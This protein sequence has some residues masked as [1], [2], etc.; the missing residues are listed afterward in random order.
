M[1]MNTTKMNV[2]QILKLCQDQAVVLSVDG[3][4]LNASFDQRPTDQLIGL[5]R[6]NKAALVAAITAHQAQRKLTQA[7]GALI[8]QPR[9]ENGYGLS[10]AQTRLWMAQKLS[11]NSAN[12]NMPIALRVTGAFDYNIAKQAFAKVVAKH[13][14]LRTRFVEQDGKVLQFVEPIVDFT[15]E[16]IDATAHSQGQVQGLIDALFAHR[17]DLAQAP[18]VKAQLVKTQTDGQPCHILVMVVHHLVCDAWSINLMTQDFMQFYQG[19]CHGQSLSGAAAL[20]YIDYVLWQQKH[21]DDDALAKQLNY[22]QQRLKNAPLVHSLPLDFAR[23]NHTAIDGAQYQYRIDS[24]LAER[25]LQSAERF[26]ITEFVL[27]HSAWALC[28]KLLG[29]EQD[30]VVGT[31]VA[32]RTVAELE[33]VVGMFVN[34]LALRSDVPFDNLEQ[35]LLAFKAIN[36]EAQAN[37][38][39]QFEQVLSALA[40]KRNPQYAPVFQL[41]LTVNQV[42][43]DGIAMPGL[44][45]EPLKS[46]VSLAKFE[47]DLTAIFS[48]EGLVLNWIFDKNLYTEQTIAQFSQCLHSV[49]MGIAE[50]SLSHDNLL[51]PQQS[52]YL[53][54]LNQPCWAEYDGQSLTGAFAQQVAL[55]PEAIALSLQGERLTFGALELAAN[56]LAH[57]LIELNVVKGDSVAIACG[58]SFELIVAIL[59]CVKIGAV[60]VP[61]DNHYPLA[62]KSFM[63]ADTNAKVVLYGD[64][65]LSDGEAIVAQLPNLQL[66]HIDVA[67]LLALDSAAH[68]KAPVCHVSGDDLAYVIYTSGSTGK[69]KGVMVSQRN[70]WRSVLADKSLAIGPEDTLAYCANPAF[71]AS[72]WEIWVSL[73]NGARL[74]IVSDQQLQDLAQFKACLTEASVS[75]LQLT[76]GLF[77]QIARE[78]L[79][80]FEKL[81]ML[82]IG[83]DAP[84]IDAVKTVLERGAPTRF[85]HTYGPTETVA[86]ATYYELSG[87]DLTAKALPIGK[88][89]ANTTAYVLDEQLQPVVSG[90]I[91]E[92]YLGGDGVAKGYLNRPELTETAFIDN[93]FGA[94]KLY[95]TGDLVRMSAKGELVFYGRI[96]QQLKIRGFR[97][98]PGEIEQHLNRIAGV[99]SSVVTAVSD[100]TSKRLVAYVKG[101]GDVNADM[102][103]K[104]LGDTLP[105]YMIPSFFVMMTQWPLTNNGKIDKRALPLPS[106]ALGA[107]KYLAPNTDTEAQLQQLFSE[108]LK[109]PADKISTDANFFTLGGDSILSI[110]L[111]NKAAKMGLHFNPNVLFQSPT[112]AKIAAA[113]SQGP[114]VAAPQIEICGDLPLLPVQIAFMQEP[115]DWHHANQAVM[116]KMP[117]D[118][119]PASLSLIVEKLYQRHD[120]LRLRYQISPS[121]K[122]EFMPLTANMVARAVSIRSNEQADWAFLSEAA[123]EVHQTMQPQQADIFKVVYWPGN[124]SDSHGRLLLAIHHL[125]VDTVSW[126]I[127][128]DDFL[129]LYQQFSQNEPLQLASKTSSY[130]Q[131]GEY[132]RQYGKS[133]ELLAQRSYWHQQVSGDVPSLAKRSQKPSQVEAKLRRAGFELSAEQSAKLNKT[134]YQINE[135]L[136]SALLLANQ[137]CFGSTALKLAFESHGRYAPFDKLDLNQTVGWF[138]LSYPLMLSLH[139]NDAIEQVVE[140]VL[141]TTQSVPDNGLGFGVLKEILGDEVL[142]A[143]QLPEWLFNYYGHIDSTKAQAQQIELA[144]ENPGKLQSDKRQGHYPLQFE[145]QVSDGCL[146]ASVSFCQSEYEQSVLQG[147][148]DK[149]AD[150]LLAMSELK[151]SAHPQFEQS[152]TQNAIVALNIDQTGPAKKPE[153]FVF[154]PFSGRVDCYREL[155]KQLDEQASVYGVQAPFVS[156]QRLRF[157]NIA[158]LAEFYAQGIVATQPKGPYRLMGWS[159]GAQLA[160]YVAIALQNKGHQV[161]YLNL[162]EPMLPDN[163]QVSDKLDYLGF[164]L[165]FVG[166]EQVLIDSWQSKQEQD[167]G[168]EALVDS[169]AA[170]VVAQNI[171]TLD[172][173]ETVKT[174]LFAGVDYRIAKRDSA[175]LAKIDTLRLFKTEQNQEVDY[176]ASWSEWFSQQAETGVVVGEH[177]SM[178]SD[179]QSLAQIVNQLKADLDC[180]DNG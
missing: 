86:F 28:M 171:S 100:G 41:M 76:A 173:I 133:P 136:L 23:S 90:R 58:R 1:N 167:A 102:L 139:Q 71:D 161:D 59:A 141:Q 49:L 158:S 165:G 135:L 13:E 153:L 66:S 97:I 51:G 37:Q 50:N 107:D 152:W 69:A 123:T 118:F 177:Q 53:A 40:L 113:I 124:T 85:I 33:N 166:L 77:K 84:D 11:G 14:A 162:L 169:A 7:K 172:D 78:M 70:V 98:E 129:T 138:T 43:Q 62:R 180:K 12:Y 115:D 156:G 61:M 145:A 56:R 35:Y 130:Q 38:D 174:V 81:R 18:L 17:F 67:E 57:R 163:D 34:T 95:K 117:A 178:L 120:A 128:L 20:G 176:F 31:P 150:I 45:F 151:S 93:P 8:V 132:L 64:E 131:W 116:L 73:L 16:Y 159:A 32:N 25:L 80:H 87:K 15:L 19:I 4:K 39:V 155:A 21:L 26:G 65:Q 149:M 164:L 48:P 75:V 29:G 140:R 27:I 108:V 104:A 103:A 42:K 122:A 119:D 175:C 3:D 54:T 101:E 114:I 99:E 160:Y 68:D 52:A 112:I 9:H 179:K 154:H 105:S 137:H 79:G 10:G 126:R 82:L 22:W 142:N 88:V 44:G 60:Y 96:D 109:L 6:D 121:L 46:A 83:G 125:S 168:F 146:S 127:L 89:M 72:T 170:F 91:A 30:V 47:L 74:E 111:T 157:D 134:G 2:T 148:M 144:K 94:G 63:L 143:A 36:A 147:L 106:E 92:L 55:R 110:E 24:A 5:I